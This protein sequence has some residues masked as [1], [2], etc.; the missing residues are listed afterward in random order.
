LG[1]IAPRTFLE[2]VPRAGVG[3]R[4]D[5]DGLAKIE[6]GE[7]RVDH[8]LSSRIFFTIFSTVPCRLYSAG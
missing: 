2:S 8:G 6:A 4:R 5:G 1:T 3:E 7:R